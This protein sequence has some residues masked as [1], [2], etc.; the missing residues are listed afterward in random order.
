MTETRVNPGIERA[1]ALA[2]GREAGVAL[3]VVVA[4]VALLFAYLAT[5]G[6]RIT[7][8]RHA[9]LPFVWI[10]VS[11]WLVLT[12]HERAITPSTG[13]SW[14]AVAV[15]VGYFVL[16]AA[17]GSPLGLSTE[18]TDLQ[19]VWATPGWGPMVLYAGSTFRVALVPFEVVGYLAL[20]YAVYRAVTVTSRS[21]FAGT[22]ALFSCVSCA[23][24]L[25]AAVAGLFG[26]SVATLHPGSATYDVATSVF[27]LTAVLLV[28]GTPLSP[29]D[30]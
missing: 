24:P 12:L 25:L 18:A 11:V 5:T 19:V 22:L 8:V 27:V 20:T 13:R 15:G 4:L 2:T 21:V 26:A 30:T 23:L 9:L 3:A 1:L 6:I 10:G 16:L 28:A 29:R 17:V 14:I 7:S